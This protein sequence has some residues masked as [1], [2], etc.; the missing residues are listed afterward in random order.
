MGLQTVLGCLDEHFDRYLLIDPSDGLDWRDR[1]D[2]V[3][4]PRGAGIQPG[5]Y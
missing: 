1:L 2:G 4:G 3:L 5:D